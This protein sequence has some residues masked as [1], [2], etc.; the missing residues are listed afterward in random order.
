MQSAP[1]SKIKLQTIAATSAKYEKMDLNGHT[2][3]YFKNDS[4]V[5]TDSHFYQEISW[6]IEKEGQ[7]IIYRLGS[8]SSAMTKE[9]LM[10]AAK[11][12]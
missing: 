11:S 10:E 3:H 6:M 12:L 5:Y 4:Y 1:D 7:A 8:D 2:A 9:Q